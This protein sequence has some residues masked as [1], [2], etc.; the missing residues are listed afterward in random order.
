MKKLILFLLLCSVVAD[1]QLQFRRGNASAR[2]T[3]SAGEPG[4]DRDSLDL[5]IGS[6][7][8]NVLIAGRSVVYGKATYA[9]D[10]GST[11]AYA[12]TLVPAPT[13]YWTGM[14][15]AFRANTA[16]TGGATLNVNSLGAKTIYKGPLVSDTLETGDISASSV[17]TAVFADSAFFLQTGTPDTRANVVMITPFDGASTSNG[18]SNGAYDINFA[19]FELKQSIRTDTLVC[20]ATGTLASGDSLIAGIYS[21]DGAVLKASTAWANMNAATPHTIRIPFSSSVVL[22]PGTYLI[23]YAHN[24]A[25]APTVL[26][27]YETTTTAFRIAYFTKF[28]GTTHMGHVVLSGLASMPSSITLSSATIYGLTPGPPIFLLTGQ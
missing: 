28:S 22:K 5:W 10:A 6:D 20:Y 21:Y 11:D 7:S 13:K 17:L 24:T 1:A 19:P 9:T 8:G 4:L 3:L 2:P 14:R 16:N 27:S 15:I 25:T 23:A 12:I 18:W 26:C